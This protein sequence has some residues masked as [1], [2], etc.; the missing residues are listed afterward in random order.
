MTE[1]RDPSHIRFFQGLL[2]AVAVMVVIGAFV[3]G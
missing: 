1:R 3:F 2:F